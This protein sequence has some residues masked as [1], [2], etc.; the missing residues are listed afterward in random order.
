MLKVEERKL[1]SLLPNTIEIPH[2]LMMLP[3]LSHICKN[4]KLNFV[5]KNKKPAVSPK[6]LKFFWV[7]CAMRLKASPTEPD[8]T[9]Q[10]KL[11]L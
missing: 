8:I 7:V 9:G 5:H 1:V 10:L 3:K 4:T 2:N 6:L 11:K